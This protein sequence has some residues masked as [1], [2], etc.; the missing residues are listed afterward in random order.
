[1]SSSL[2]DGIP[3]RGGISYGPV[4][5]IENKRG[6]TIVG[7]GLTKAYNLE[8]SQQWSGGVVDKECFELFKGETGDSII[9][10]LLSDKLNPLIIKYNIPL[11]DF[12]FKIGYGFCWPK[13]NSIKNV[14][15]IILINSLETFSSAKISTWV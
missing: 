10:T 12:K 6:T 4:S 8:S 11:K 2:A 7:L 1:M 9:Q 14:D 5:I 3:L 13:F 15:D